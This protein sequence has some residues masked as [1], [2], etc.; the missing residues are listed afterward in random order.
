MLNDLASRSHLVRSNRPLR[1]GFY[2]LLTLG[3]AVCSQPLFEVGSL[4][5]N[6]D[7][8]YLNGGVVEFMQSAPANKL[9]VTPVMVCCLLG[10]MITVLFLLQ[11]L[12]LTSN[13]RFRSNST[14]ARA[15]RSNTIESNQASQPTIVLPL[16]DRLVIMPQSIVAS[17]CRSMAS[18]PQIECVPRTPTQL[19][20]LLERSVAEVIVL[21]GPNITM[22][23]SDVV[24]GIQRLQAQP[25]LDVVMPQIRSSFDRVYARESSLPALYQ[26][27]QTTFDLQQGD[28]AA[29]EVAVAAAVAHPL[30]DQDCY[31]VRRDGLLSLLNSHQWSTDDLNPHQTDHLSPHQWVI[32]TYQAPNPQFCGV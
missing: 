29:V 9:E 19:T 32:E 8:L 24:H 17:T 14:V 13:S 1:N 25:D 30:R 2:F 10:L 31:I 4:A 26:L 21:T 6:A 5:Q 12:Y 22:K 11:P 3:C 20:A 7:S 18:S 28:S 23:L 16:L 27:L 15:K